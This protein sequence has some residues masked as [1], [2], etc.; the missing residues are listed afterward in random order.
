MFK[1]YFLEEYGRKTIETEHGFAMYVVNEKDSEFFL[2]DFYIRPESRSTYESK[3][4]F[5]VCRAKAKELGLKYLTGCVS[6]N[7][8]PPEVSTKVL[9]CYLTLGFKVM[10]AKNDQVIIMMEV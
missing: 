7:V 5:E 1:D 6:F 3:K 9:K 4:L 2:C 10:S 8:K